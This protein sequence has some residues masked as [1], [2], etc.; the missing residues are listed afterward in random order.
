MFG[1]VMRQ[2]PYHGLI[3]VNAWSI[4]I[5]DFL[6]TDNGD[7]GE[8]GVSIEVINKIINT[9]GPCINIV[10][11]WSLAQMSRISAATKASNH[12]LLDKARAASSH[13]CHEVDNE[14]VDNE[15][16]DNEEVDNEE[17]DNRN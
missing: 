11:T 3:Y 1:S 16:V 9:D 5:D 4:G 2:L 10:R 15:E 12:V 7:R 14:A 17:V 6:I 8:A 13:C